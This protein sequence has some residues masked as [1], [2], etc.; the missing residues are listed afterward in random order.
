MTVV[1][2]YESLIT[3]K[4]HQLDGVIV[5]FLWTFSERTIESLTKIKSEVNRRLTKDIE[6]LIAIKL[7]NRLTALVFSKF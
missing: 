4:H 6:R 2:L 1:T 3:L 5:F 7:F